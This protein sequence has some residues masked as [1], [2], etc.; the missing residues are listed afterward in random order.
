MAVSPVWTNSQ[1][2][3]TELTLTSLVCGSTLEK[4]NSVGYFTFGVPD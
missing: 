1:V 2:I 3:R 4:S